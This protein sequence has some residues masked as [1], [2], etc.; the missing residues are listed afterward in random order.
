MNINKENFDGDRE[1][2][3][4][5]CHRGAAHPV[6]IPVISAEMKPMEMMVSEAMPAAEPPKPEELLDKYLA[7]VGGAEALKKISSR[8]QKGTITAF[9][10]QQFPIEIYSKAPDM[11][12]SI[13]HFKQGDSV[14]AYNGTQGWLQTQARVHMMNDQEKAEAYIDADISFAA[15]VKAMYTKFMTR[16]GETVDGHDT[17]LVIGRTEGKPPLR[18]F[19]DQRTGL[20]VRMVRYVDSPL[21]YNPTQVDYAD[22]REASGVKVPFEWTLARPGNRFTI[23]ISELQQNVP[24]DAARFTPPPPPM[25]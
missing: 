5:S 11:R 10:N 23:K 20:L 19:L 9:G 22:Y 14:T 2:T 24:V 17:W 12:A 4:Y 16:P 13:T 7:A 21:G 25:H 8:V 15:D 1:V 18:L 6:A 3:C